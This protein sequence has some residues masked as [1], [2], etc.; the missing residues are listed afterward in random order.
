MSYEDE[1]MGLTQRMNVGYRESRVKE[2]NIYYQTVFV[3]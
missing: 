1:G 3:I 2:R